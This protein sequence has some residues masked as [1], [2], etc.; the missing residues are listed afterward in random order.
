MK[1]ETMRKTNLLVGVGLVEQEDINK[2]NKDS[3]NY[4]EAKKKAALSR[5]ED[6]G[7]IYIRKAEVRDDNI[8]VRNFIPPRYSL[9]TCL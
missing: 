6:I 2:Q 9:I 5:T 1:T 7:V 8:W 4:S 3:I